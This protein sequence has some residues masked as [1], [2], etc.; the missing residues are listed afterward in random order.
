VGI[1][2]AVVA[3]LAGWGVVEGVRHAYGPTPAGWA[4]LLSGMLGGVVVAV[5]FLAVTYPLDRHDLRPLVATVTGRIR[6]KPSPD[7]RGAS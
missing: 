5:V 4:S 2:A 6:R 3:G 1:V 7:G